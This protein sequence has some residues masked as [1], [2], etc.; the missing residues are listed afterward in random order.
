MQ[1]SFRSRPRWIALLIGTLWICAGPVRPLA[2]DARRLDLS[3]SW[4]FQLDPADAGVSDRWFERSLPQTLQ[5]PGSLQAQGFGT[6]PSLE[7]KWTGSIRPEVFQMPRYAP[8]RTADNFKMPFWLQ[9]KRCY[10]GPAWYQRTVTIPADW[11]G[12]RITLHLERC[13]W[14]TTVWVDGQQVGEGES[15]SVPH[16]VDLTDS[17]P[18]GDHR[19]TLRIDNRLL[20]DVGENSHSVTDHTQTNWN[21]VVGRLELRAGPPVWIDDVQV[22]PDVGEGT[23]RVCVTI[24]N[25]TG[26]AAR[27]RLDVRASCGDAAA[28]A[29][30]QDVTVTG[31]SLAT[32]V[33]LA[34]GPDARLWDEH[35]P[36]L[37]TLHAQLTGDTADVA[38]TTFGMRQIATAGTRFVLNGQPIQ[39][40]GTLECCI[41]PLTGYPATDAGAWRTIIQRAKDF[42]LN[43]LRFHSWCPPEAAFCAAD[44]LGFYFQVECASWANGAAR[45]GD[46]NPL[47]AWLY[48]EADRILRAYGNHPSF[49]LLA[50]GNEPAGPGP[51]NQGEEYLASW[52]AHYK[53]QAP[54]QLVTCASG[55]PY[56]PESHYHVMHAPL[57]QH[58]QFDALPP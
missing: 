16:V 51:Q 10:V 27:V 11:R 17:L 48:R 25:R 1:S 28:Q 22:Y 32:E 35:Q 55:W 37:Y 14:F 42:G 15:L 5:L 45:V 9:P 52:V 47:D 2:A 40:R 44:E 7:T 39:L 19:L 36:H 24:G 23:A 12:Q 33:Q 8:Y 49:L 46:G 21:G 6:P 20:I 13:H 31:E 26:T 29:A 38:Q 3:G 34:L 41:F 18:P 50:Y 57:R 56:L 30:P 53:Q 43:H 4:S 54:R 58:R